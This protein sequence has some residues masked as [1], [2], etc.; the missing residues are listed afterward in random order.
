MNFI[1]QT[2]YFCRI[3][4]TTQAPGDAQQQVVWMAKP[5]PVPGCPPGLEYLTQ[6]DQILVHQQIELFEGELAS[7]QRLENSSCYFSCITVTYP[8][9]FEL[10]IE[11]KLPCPVLSSEAIHIAR[12]TSYCSCSFYG[13]V[14]I[15]V[16][17]KAKSLVRV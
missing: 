5:Q 13:S 12:F 6:I 7:Y 8:L 9:S 4:A 15:P 1:D 11:I 14:L 16:A 17:V 3:M 10:E 2:V